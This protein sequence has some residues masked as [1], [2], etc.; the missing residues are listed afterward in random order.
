M[1]FCA[2]ELIMG[3][4]WGDS[5]HNDWLCNQT[6]NQV[7]STSCSPNSYFLWLVK[8]SYT[9]S[10]FFIL[11]HLI[12]NYFGW[13]KCQWTSQKLYPSVFKY[14]YIQTCGHICETSL[15]RTQN[16]NISESLRG[17]KLGNLEKH[18]ARFK[19]YCVSSFN[20]QILYAMHL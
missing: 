9:H 18:L 16:F 11:F 19:F 7:T 1:N 10:K 6:L 20:F 8:H 13:I 3:S 17:R 4:G 15:K 12:K 2:G 5:V 14:I